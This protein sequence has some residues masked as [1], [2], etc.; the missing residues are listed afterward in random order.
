[1]GLV[2]L[3][4]VAELRV[5]VSALPWQMNLKN[6]KLMGSAY[7]EGCLV[8]RAKYR[9]KQMVTLQNRPEQTKNKQYFKTVPVLQPLPPNGNYRG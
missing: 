6:L 4:L 3:T 1:M 8:N 2:I 9:S 5:Q 7:Y